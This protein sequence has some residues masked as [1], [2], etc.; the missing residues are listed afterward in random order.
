MFQNFVLGWLFTMSIINT[1]MLAEI[2]AFL[3]SEDD[4]NED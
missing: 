2:V 3:G 1:F 4:G